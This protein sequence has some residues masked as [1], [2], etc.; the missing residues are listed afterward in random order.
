VASEDESAAT[1]ALEIV[2][3]HP[4][5]AASAMETI[6]T[7]WL[8]N[9]DTS[10]QRLRR[11]LDR[12]WNV[13]EVSSQVATWLAEHPSFL[14][15]QTESALKTLACVQGQSLPELW[16]TPIADWL[17]LADQATA[18]RLAASFAEV[19]WMLPRDASLVN[20][21]VA[22]ANDSDA[23]M[24]ERIGF[25]CALPPATQGV[26]E[27]VLATIAN[28]LI[29]DDDA[30]ASVSTAALSHVRLPFD[31]AAALIQ[32]LEMVSPVNLQPV[33][34]AILHVDDAKIDAALL[35]KFSTLPSAK[36]VPQSAIMNA[37]SNRSPSVRRS[38]T[39]ALETLNAPPADVSLVVEDW[40]AKLPDG[41]AARGHKVF[42]GSKAACV[43]CH[44]VGYVG[45][46]IG[47]EL[48]RIGKSR[49]RRDLVEAILYPSARLEQ[50]YRSTRVLLT[51]GRVLNG[52]L[53]NRS[54]STLE[55]ICGVD[56]RCFVSMDDV[57][58]IEPSD[59]S[60]MPAG[61]EQT[62]TLQQFADLIAFLEN[63]R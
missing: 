2:T 42:R 18:L 35:A 15:A 24:S 51:D 52:M 50:S 4:E 53:A 36:S 20:A 59:V 14:A 39:T 26:D 9:D 16:V 29:S 41:D 45:G 17:S 22:K 61:L 3:A 43:Q 19:K 58:T 63:A 23:V 12:W 54:D 21:F 13:E 48:T 33:M 56:Q 5:F 47:P 57:E 1:M 30:T 62:L 25:V 46:K 7:W 28:G 8:A 6:N 11:L 60:I 37:I 34:Q 38:W 40:L 10:H 44:Q 32:R 31:T 27:T 49:T 55:L